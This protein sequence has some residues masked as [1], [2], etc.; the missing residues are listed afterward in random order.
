MRIFDARFGIPVVTI[1][2]ACALVLSAAPPAAAAGKSLEA[3][4]NFIRDQVSAQG[5]LSYKV[6]IHDTA[7]N[8][9]FSNDMT[10]EARN[11]VSDVGQC[12]VSFHWSTSL[13]GGSKQDFDTWW[14]FAHIRK[15]EVVNREQE[16]RAQAAHD[17]HPSWVATVSPPLWVVTATFDDNQDRVLDF[18]DKGT[19]DR[20]LH[21]IDHAMDLC[22]APKESF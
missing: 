9:D 20:V 18:T 8:E 12:R 13:N 17:G 3:T 6:S 7:T 22:G 11:V 15:V 10:G 1:M 19:A 4:L 21:A 14:D 2:G 16:L 5:R